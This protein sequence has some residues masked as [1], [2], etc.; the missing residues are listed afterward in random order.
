MDLGKSME[1]MVT[2]RP[3]DFRSSLLL[4]PSPIPGGHV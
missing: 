1:R 3:R 4:D 2:M